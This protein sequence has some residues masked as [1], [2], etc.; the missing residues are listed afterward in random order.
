MPPFA[1]P[2]GIGGGGGGGGGGGILTLCT[3][4]RVAD[5]VRYYGRT[6]MK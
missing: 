1:P 4:L 3:L 5:I 2:P 6:A